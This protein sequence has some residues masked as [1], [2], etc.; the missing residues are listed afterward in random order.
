M[1]EPADRSSWWV[2]WKRL[3]RRDPAECSDALV[4]MSWSAGTRSNYA[5]HIRRALGMLAATQHGVDKSKLLDRYVRALFAKGRSRSYMRGTISAV[6]SLED[7]GW[8]DGVVQA[9]HWRMAKSTI[10]NTEEQ[11]PYGGLEAL[12]VL[13]QSCHTKEQWSGFPLAVLSFT[14]LCLWGRCPGFDDKESRRT[15]GLDATR[16]VTTVAGQS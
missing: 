15:S 11:R 1:G 9:I 16:T 7:L 14:C 8:I 2:A 13:A 6:R 3:N 10:R 12:S 5:V 4:A